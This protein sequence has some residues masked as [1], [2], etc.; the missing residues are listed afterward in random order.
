MRM[1]RSTFG[2]L[3]RVRLMM[4]TCCSVFGTLVMPAI[5]GLRMV[6]VSTNT[7]ADVW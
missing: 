5:S 3:S 7:R 6:C 4:A 1:T 2:R